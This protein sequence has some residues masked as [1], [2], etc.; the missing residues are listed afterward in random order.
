MD[1]L[2]RKEFHPGAVIF[3]EGEAGETAFV[4]ESG[5]VEISAFRGDTK[6]VI[7][8]LGEGELFGEMALIDGQVRSATARAT[9]NTILIIIARD[10][11]ERRI[12]GVDPLLNLFLKV[13]LKR[14]RTPTRLLDLHRE[15]PD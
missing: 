3:R 8:T 11:V 9:T 6:V 2:F 5:G 13:I 7:A 12:D 4:I 1:A 15:H 10:Q 14:L